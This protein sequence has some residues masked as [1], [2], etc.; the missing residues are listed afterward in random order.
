MNNQ[1]E[2][3]KELIDAVKAYGL[4][5]RIGELHRQI[6]PQLTGEA[7]KPAPVRSMRSLVF[8]AAAIFIALLT[9]VSVYI[10]VSS[11]ADNLFNN[12]YV[13]YNVG[14]ERS[15]DGASNP[16]IVKF[17]EIGQKAL[18]D[19]NTA[20]AI[21][22]FSRVLS[23]NQTNG[24]S[25]L[26]DD[27]EF[28]LALAYLRAGQVDQAYEQFLAIKN[29]KDHLYNEEVSSWYLFKLKVLSWKNK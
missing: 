7:P 20:N 1:E 22:A 8:K 16:E 12:K 4:K 6:V 9:L 29:N 17:F 26:R 18:T 27:A 21:V 25:I 14:N 11:T 23:I 24:T 10:F 5:Q 3:K 2:E 15:A 13:A 19:D 28:Y